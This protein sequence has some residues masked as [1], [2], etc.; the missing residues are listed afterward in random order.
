MGSRPRR[1]AAAHGGPSTARAEPLRPR[2]WARRARDDWL[3]GACRQTPGP[4]RRE[5]KP[6]AGATA[7]RG[8]AGGE[9][10][11]KG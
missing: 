10:A 11:A 6:A 3:L 1:A 8:E 9:G 4:G 2:V 5:G 7:T